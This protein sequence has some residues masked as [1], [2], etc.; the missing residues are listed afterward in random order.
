MCVACMCAYAYMYVYAC[1][2][3]VCMCVVCMCVV[4]C[5]LCECLSCANGLHNI[6]LLVTR[7]SPLY[8]AII[9]LHRL[10][11]PSPFSRISAAVRFACTHHRMMCEYTIISC[12][13]HVQREGQ[14][15][16]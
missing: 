9:Y 10:K 12:A 5:A 3:V 1:M 11:Q 2:C 7:K 6:R 4:L 14:E 8:L 16:A 15:L 13:P